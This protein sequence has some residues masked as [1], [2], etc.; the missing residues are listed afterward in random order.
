MS[1]AGNPFSALQ[2]RRYRRIPQKNIASKVKGAGKQHFF[3]SLTLTEASVPIINRV[4]V[5]T[6]DGLK[7]LPRTA[8][9]GSGRNIT[10]MRDAD[11][12]RPFQTIAVCYGESFR[13]VGGSVWR[14]ERFLSRN[15]TRPLSLYSNIWVLEVPRS[16]SLKVLS[17]FRKEDIFDL[18]ITEPIF[19]GHLTLDR[20][21]C[22]AVRFHRTTGALSSS[23]FCGAQHR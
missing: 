20:A 19:I 16:P 5:F 12:L 7:R 2:E 10:D 15:K 22:E 14:H 4:A 18:V 8:L 9:E 23:E 13:C 3:P 6:G 11:R 1:S 17:K 21:H